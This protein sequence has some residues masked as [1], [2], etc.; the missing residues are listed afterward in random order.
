MNE[1]EIYYCKDCRTLDY[2]H[3]Q[4]PKCGSLNIVRAEESLF[5]SYSNSNAHKLTDNIDYCLKWI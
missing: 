4:C 2:A 5:I 1:K 3:G